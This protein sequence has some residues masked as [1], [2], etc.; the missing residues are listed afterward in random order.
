MTKDQQNRN[1]W[2]VSCEKRDN[3]RTFS[4]RLYS[5]IAPITKVFSYDLRIVGSF[6]MHGTSQH[7]GQTRFSDI[8]KS[9]KPHRQLGSNAK[10]SL[11]RGELVK[12]ILSDYKNDSDMGDENKDYVRYFSHG[13]NGRPS[14]IRD[15]PHLLYSSFLL[16]AFFNSE[17]IL[18]KSL[19]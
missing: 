16:E 10:D 14:S 8:W 1:S 12:K 15:P 18:G 3:S 6:G 2:N 17:N 7:I 19:L 5:I 9:H 13:R 4:L 11:Q